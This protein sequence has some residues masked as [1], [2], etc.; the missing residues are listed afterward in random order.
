MK[1]VVIIGRSVILNI[2]QVCVPDIPIRDLIIDTQY[3]SVHPAILAADN[4][5]DSSGYPYMAVWSPDQII[6]HKEVDRSIGMMKTD[7]FG[8]VLRGR[9]A[10]VKEHVAYESVYRKN[11]LADGHVLVALGEKIFIDPL[12]D[13]F[14][15]RTV[16]SLEVK[17]ELVS[18][19]ASDWYP[20]HQ[21][22][23]VFEEL[24]E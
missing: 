12:H 22:L 11:Y 10:T 24:P 18:K 8:T 15:S 23:V 21:F 1:N 13:H 5:I 19:G 17:L 7:L 16:D 6:S 9:H 2:K 3:D 4:L 14:I 20:F